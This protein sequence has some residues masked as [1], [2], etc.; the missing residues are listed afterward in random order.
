MNKNLWIN[1][2]KYGLG[3]AVLI[4]AISRNWTTPADGSGPGL[5][6]ILQRPVRWWAL[7]LAAALS[8]ASLL[9]TFVRWYILVRAQDLPFTLINATRLGLVGYFFNTCLP[10]SI[11]GD[12]IKATAIARQQSRRTIA[13]ATVLLDRAVGLW[14][15]IWL[16]AI[17]GGVFWLIGTPELQDQLSLQIIVLVAFALVGLTSI[18]YGILNGL[19]EFRGERFAGRLSRLPK[20]G[21][22]AAELWRAVWMYRRKPG[23]VAASLALSLLVHLGNVLTFYFAVQTFEEIGGDRIPS[24]AE[25]FLIVPIGMVV[26]AMFPTP[27]GVG[28]GEYGFGALFQMIGSS[29]A[30]GVSGSLTQRLISWVLGLTGYL[31]YLR[32]KPTLV[33]AVDKPLEVSL[34]APGGAPSARLPVVE[35]IEG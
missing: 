14:A 9:L 5:S 29:S 8:L 20:V 17:L 35:T 7:S 3:I 31:V 28:G 33:P 1:V 6:D 15:L 23:S 11:G 30:T 32:T 16:V 4:F 26:Q 25:Q 24:L 2:G 27:G 22:A 34:A 13:V 10:G 19:A 12:I 21:S 18:L